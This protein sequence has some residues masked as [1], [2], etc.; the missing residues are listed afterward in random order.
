MQRS[1]F[2]TSILSLCVPALSM[3]GCDPPDEPVANESAE[4]NAANEPELSTPNEFDEFNR[5]GI[6][7]NPA[8]AEAVAAYER[9]HPDAVFSW[10]NG[11]VDSFTSTPKLTI[12]DYALP[13][14]KQLGLS[15]EARTPKLLAPPVN[16]AE[17][18]NVGRNIDAMGDLTPLRDE[19]LSRQVVDYVDWEKPDAA[20]KALEAKAVLPILAAFLQE[21]REIFGVSPEE[22][23]IAMTQT[24]YR[25]GAFGRVARFQLMYDRDEPIIGGLGL[26]EFD[27]NWNIVGISRMII[28]P[29]KLTVEPAQV[30]A[31]QA[32][33]IA[34]HQPLEGCDVTALAVRSTVLGVDPILRRRVWE[35]ELSDGNLSDCRYGVTVDA[36][37]GE[38]LNTDDLVDRYTDAKVRR[39]GFTDGDQTAPT[40]LVTTGVYTRHASLLEHDFFYMMNDNLCS[41]TQTTCDLMENNGYDWELTSY[42]EGAYTSYSSSTKIRGAD[43]NDR[44]WSGSDFYPSHISESFSET[45]AY[46]WARWFTIWLKP[47]LDAMDLLPESTN[48]YERVL[49]IA[50]GC[51]NG[52]NYERDN[53]DWAV[54]T[55]DDKGEG[56]GVV[57]LARRWGTSDSFIACWSGYCFESVGTLTHELNHFF[58]HEY[59]GVTSSLNCNG[60]QQL[61][62]THE[63]ILGS[64]LM[65]AFWHYYYDVGYDPTAD[66]NFLYHSDTVRGRVHV[67]PETLMT[68]STWLCGVGD[69]YTSGRVAGQVMWKIFHGVK[70]TGT[71]Q[72]PITKPATDTEFIT[73]AY[74]AA[75]KQAASTYKSRSEYANRVMEYLYQQ[76]W[77]LSDRADYCDLWETHGLHT[78]INVDYCTEE[79]P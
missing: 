74:T 1:T 24:G 31:E 70:V 53:E 48:D 16:S 69:N 47:A 14:L 29:D 35:M 2:V 20:T 58:L 36:G 75:E 13:T 34:M 40:Q 27:I 68:L 30:G 77:P 67:S 78:L 22:L 51:K 45:N 63:G 11:Q 46:H 44:D 17:H 73:I 49:I 76:E 38:V 6:A 43:R 25:H 8:I 65:Q 9:E 7:P 55:E 72:D 39:W 71:D 4:F 62:Y 12:P 15:T 18:P 28:T 10:F 32:S 26:V 64:T 54:S 50:D 21:N 42:C 41:S 79:A 5:D 61:E 59:V 60:S 3:L 37:T 52:A 56:G 19:E 66:T 57:R 33:R 23:K